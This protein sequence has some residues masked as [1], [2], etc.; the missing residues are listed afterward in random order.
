MARDSPANTE[1]EKGHPVDYAEGSPQHSVGVLRRGR[2]PKAGSHRARSIEGVMKEQ[3]ISFH[4]V[5]M[6]LTQAVC[7][8]FKIQNVLPS[9]CGGLVSQNTGLALP[10]AHASLVRQQRVGSDLPEEDVLELV[11]GHATTLLPLGERLVALELR[12]PLRLLYHTEGAK[13]CQRQPRGGV[14]F[15]LRIFFS[16][17]KKNL[18]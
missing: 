8:N 15:I 5:I 17:L 11:Q 18:Q 13:K 9:P 14:V 3:N 6:A 7:G 2:P 1:V 10:S 12:L 4:P 16:P